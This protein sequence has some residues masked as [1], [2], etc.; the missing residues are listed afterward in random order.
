[1]LQAHLIGFLCAASASKLFIAGGH[2]AEM[3]MLM[4]ALDK[5]AF[6]PRS[7]VVAATDRMSATKALARE[8]LWAVRHAS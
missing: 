1:M 2:T 7:Y 5:H 8:A 4:D 3:L 6:A